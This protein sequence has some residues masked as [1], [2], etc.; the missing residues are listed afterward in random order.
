[1]TPITVVVNNRNLQVKVYAGHLNDAGMRALAPVGHVVSV[2]QELPDTYHLHCHS[3][4]NLHLTIT[5]QYLQ[6]TYG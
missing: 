2:C 6:E 5:H 3:Y 1:M 4:D